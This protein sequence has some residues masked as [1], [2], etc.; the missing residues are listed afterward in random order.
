MGECVGQRRGREASSGELEIDIVRGNTMDAGQFDEG[1]ELDLFV[2]AE[3]PRVLW[4]LYPQLV[5]DLVDG[6][7]T[8]AT[9]CR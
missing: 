9:V 2:D 7:Q 1:A 4:V 6:D 5:F 8:A 3:Y